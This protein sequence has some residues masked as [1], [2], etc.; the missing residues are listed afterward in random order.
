MVAPASP[1]QL[2][3]PKLH[4]FLQDENIK[5]LSYGG[6]GVGS[7]G[8]GAIQFLAKDALTQKQLTEYLK[9]KGLV[10]YTLAITPKHRIRKAIIP[11]AGFGTRLYPA[12]RYMKK[13]MMPLVDRD[14]LAKPAILILLEQLHEAGIEEICLVVGGEN[15]VRFYQDYFQTPLSDEHLEKLSDTMRAYENRIREI[16][17]KLRYRIQ[18]E[19]RGFGHAVYQ[20]HDF[21]ENEAVLLL[22]GDT[23]YTSEYKNCSLQM[24]EAYEKLEKPL[25]SIHDIPLDQTCY[26][27]IITGEWENDAC[28]RITRFVE[29]PNR[30][31]AEETFMTLNAEKKPACYAVFGQ[32]VLTP[33]VFEKLKES[34]Q[35]EVNPTKEVDMTHALCQFIGK[36]LTGIVIDGQ[37]HDIGNPAAYRETAAAFTR[38]EG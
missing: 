19:R 23:L 11:V 29:K 24:I 34:I 7:Q 5:R 13:E 28:M 37:M 9:Q 12:T 30:K 8:D 36:G 20:C 4:R 3:A 1:E 16:G 15:D 21:C 26:F 14:G 31:K 33:D 2:S 22:L 32:Y 25:I 17:N 6:K 38:Q 10:P 18:R 27:G 35:D